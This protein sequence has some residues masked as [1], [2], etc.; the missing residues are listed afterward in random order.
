MNIKHVQE[1]HTYKY[2]LHVIHVHED[3]YMYMIKKHK[4]MTVD[5][6]CT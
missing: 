3:V 6:K 2:I 5:N 1:A 4:Y